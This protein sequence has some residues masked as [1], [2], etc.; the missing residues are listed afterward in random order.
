MKVETGV[1]VC[2]HKTYIKI[3]VSVMPPC[4]CLCF[5][6]CLIFFPNNQT[7]ICFLTDSFNDLLYFY[8]Y[9]M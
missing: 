9:M 5:L 6:L 3:L 4:C 1:C 7:L 8:V 2:V